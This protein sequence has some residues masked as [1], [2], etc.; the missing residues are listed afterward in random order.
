MTCTFSLSGGQTAWPVK[1]LHASYS[2]SIRSSQTDMPPSLGAGLNTAAALC[3]TCIPDKI[4][5]DMP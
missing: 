3:L 1:S 5:I 4:A 2:F